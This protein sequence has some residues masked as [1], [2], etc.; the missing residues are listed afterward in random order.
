MN[1]TALA[2]LFCCCLYATGA[3]AVELRIKG[4]DD[5]LLDNVRSWIGPPAE[6]GRMSF[7]A[8][9]RHAVEQARGAL[10]A[11]GYYQPELRTERA[12]SEDE[13]VCILH[14]DPGPPVLIERIDIRLEGDRDPRELTAFVADN[15]PQRGDIFHHGRY[16]SFKSSLLQQA[17]QRGY[18]GATYTVQQVLLDEERNRSDVRLTIALGARYRIG[19]IA[20]AG[21]GI[22][23]ELVARFPRFRSGDWYDGEKIAELHR[24][25]VRTGWF[26]GVRLRADPDDAQGLVVPV[27]VEYTPRKRN[28]IGIGAGFSTD[29][30]PRIQLQW[31]KPWLNAR[32]HSF[33]SYLEMSEIR[34]QLEASYLIPLRDPVTS[35]LALT[36]GLQFEDLNDHDYWLTTAGVEHRKRL[37]NKWRLIRSVDIERETDDF[38]NREFSSTM[39]IPGVALSRTESEGSPLISRGWRATGKIQFASDALLSDAT[40]EKLTLDAKG[41]HSLGTRTRAIARGSLGAVRT[42]DILEIPV[43]LRF[44]SGG[45]QSI[46]GYDYKS[47]APVDAAG[48]LI[49]GRYQAEGSLEFDYRFAERWLVAAFADRGASFENSSDADFATGVGAGIRW[50]SPIGPLRLDFAWGISADDTP[51]NVHFYMGPEL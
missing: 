12:G 29:I 31:E 30:G 33:G 34:T 20:I 36:Y 21:E 11:L 24:D 16:E 49:G 13:T 41:I 26:D 27:S 43:S 6:T 5:D 48:D 44:F 7:R 1:R 3:Q 39:L 50:L 18:F 4:I 40:M 37:D 9:E 35:Q 46:R 15:A 42:D 22:D 45:D 25:L 14:V 32:G 38:G 8:L 28:R 10:Q 19:D 23:R 51:F 47:L 2:C 17:R